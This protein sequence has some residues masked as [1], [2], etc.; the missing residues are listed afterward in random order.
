M[1]DYANRDWNGLIATYY[2]PRWE[3]F[4]AETEESLS[5]GKPFD[6][7]AFLKW[8]NDFEWKWAHSFNKMNSHPSGNP[9][10]LSQNLFDKYA[11]E[12]MDA[13]LLNL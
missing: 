8:C 12:I 6:E 7:D 10:E 11:P 1:T 9:R 4:I 5:G 13:S 2:L 3:K